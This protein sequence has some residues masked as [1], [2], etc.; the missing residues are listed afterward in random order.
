[1]KRTIPFL[2]L[3]L[4]PTVFAQ[5]EISQNIPAQYCLNYALEAIYIKDDE[6]KF[7]LNDER[8]PLLKESDDYQFSDGS[9]ITVKDIFEEEAE[10]GPDTVEFYLSLVDCK[11][12]VKN[13]TAQITVEPIPENKTIIEMEEIPKPEN[14]TI[15]DIPTKSFLQSFWDWVTSLFR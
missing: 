6:V 3:L 7:R 11:P 15:S 2:L 14:K 8:T 4:L 12:F 5:L 9:R 13:T 10:E 1:M